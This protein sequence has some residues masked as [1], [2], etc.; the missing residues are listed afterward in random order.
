MGVF[1]CGVSVTEIEGPGPRLL[2]VEGPCGHSKLCAS[3]EESGRFLRAE[4][5]KLN[6]D[7]DLEEIA[8]LNIYRRFT[9]WLDEERTTAELVVFGLNE[10][11]REIFLV[12]DR[13]GNLLAACMV[14]N[15]LDD[16]IAA[17]GNGPAPRR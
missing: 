16:A 2:F 14:E 1:R 10:G 11:A 13:H 5:Q 12:S 15:D 6:L 3:N 17:L 9:A 7:L 4:F 8:N